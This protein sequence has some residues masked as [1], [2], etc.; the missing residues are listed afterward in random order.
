M[1]AVQNRVKELMKAHNLS[2][3]MLAERAGVPLG[4]IKN[5]VSGTSRS[6]RGAMLEAL[7][8]AFDCDIASLLSESAP[9][10]PSASKQATHIEDHVF[11][12]A[13]TKVEELTTQKGVSLEGKDELKRRCVT[14]IYQYAMDRAKEQN[15]EPKIDNVYAEWVVERELEN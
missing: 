6:P 12:A 15:A 9:L 7:A 1:S 10:K 13:I 3:P 8:K 14:R 11:K 2:A 5:I 4:S